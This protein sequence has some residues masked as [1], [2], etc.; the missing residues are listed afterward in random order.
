MLMLAMV[1]VGEIQ[2]VLVLPGDPLG[3]L[4]KWCKSSLDLCMPQSSNFPSQMKGVCP[5]AGASLEYILIARSGPEDLLN[6][7]LTA[8]FTEEEGKR[9]QVGHP[10]THF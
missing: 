1:V 8:S 9:S 5:R 10:T 7:D 4:Y 2:S 3:F 6:C